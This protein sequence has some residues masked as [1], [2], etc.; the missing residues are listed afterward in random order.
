MLKN[1]QTKKFQQSEKIRLL[2]ERCGSSGS[3]SEEP[4]VCVRRARALLHQ[5]TRNG[6][7]P[8]HIA[9]YK[10]DRGAVQTLLEAGADPNA[11]LA[12]GVPPPLHLAAMSG[13]A[14]VT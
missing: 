1:F 9:V 12:A 4:E 14:E 6:T 2:L 10:G 11:P 13:N 3:D 7:T 8:L 5:R